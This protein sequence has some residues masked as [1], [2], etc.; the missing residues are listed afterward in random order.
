MTPTDNAMGVS[1]G[2]FLC[3]KQLNYFNLILLIHR[4]IVFIFVA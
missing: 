2:D 3:L 1:V 4:F